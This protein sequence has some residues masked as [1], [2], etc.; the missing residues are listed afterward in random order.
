MFTFDLSPPSQTDVGLCERNAPK[1]RRKYETRLE[2]RKNKKEQI[3]ASVSYAPVM[4]W[5]PSAVFGTVL[6]CRFILDYGIKC[7]LDL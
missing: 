6:H 2:E 7:L 4:S 1:P 5:D 3:L